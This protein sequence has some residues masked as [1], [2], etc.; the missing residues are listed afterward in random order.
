M[1]LEIDNVKGDAIHDRIQE[2]TDRLNDELGDRKL[3]L[4]SP[5][6]FRYYDNTEIAKM[7][8]TSRG[9]VAVLLF[10]ARAQLKKSIRTRLGDTQ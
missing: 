10:R 4:V 2:L 9:T 7:L 6:L 1:Q 3:F 8:G 5:E